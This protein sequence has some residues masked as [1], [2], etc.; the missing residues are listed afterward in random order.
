MDKIKF[1]LFVSLVIFSFLSK[2]QKRDTKIK[3]F[4]PEPILIG[5][6]DLNEIESNYFLYDVSGNNKHFYNGNKISHWKRDSLNH[7]IFHK[8]TH[9][10]SGSLILNKFPY[11]ILI[12]F[13]VTKSKGK[14]TL[15]SCRNYFRS[16]YSI[17]LINESDENWIEIDYLGETIRAKKKCEID[18][19][20]TVVAVFT[21]KEMSLYMN[22]E[23]VGSR[24]HTP[25]VA[26]NDVNL[27]FGNHKTNP[28][29][30]FEGV[31]DELALW[32]GVLTEKQLSNITYPISTQT[33]IH[34]IKIIIYLNQGRHPFKNTEIEENEIF[35]SLET[36]D[37]MSQYPYTS[38]PK[39]FNALADPFGYHCDYSKR[40]ELLKYVRDNP[41]SIKN[42]FFFLGDLC[43]EMTPYILEYYSFLVYYN[44]NVNERLFDM[45]IELYFNYPDLQLLN[46]SRSELSHF[47][48]L[49]D[50]GKTPL[51]YATEFGYLG[52][53]KKIIG[54]SNVNQQNFL[55]Q[56]ALSNA[57]KNNDLQLMSLLWDYGAN[58]NIKDQ[59]GKKPMDYCTTTEAKNLFFN[60]LIA[61]EKDQKVYHSLEEALKR[62]ERVFKLNLS[63]QYL[64]QLPENIVKFKNLK[65]LDL[66]NNLFTHFPEGISELTNL[67][68]LNLSKNQLTRL[69]ESIYKMD[70]LKS[71]LLSRNQLTRLP[72]N[73]H[74]MSTL[75]S[76]DIS[77]NLLTHL[78]DNIF[79]IKSLKVLNLSNNQLSS[80]GAG[81]HNLKNLTK[82]RL[83]G[84][85]LTSLPEKMYTMK[86]ITYL[87]LSFN[88]LI[89]ISE[90]IQQMERL[91]YLWLSNNQL[92]RLPE[93]LNKMHTIK[94]LNIKGNHFLQEEKEKIKKLPFYYEYEF[95]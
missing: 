78:S 38:N 8:E 21:E 14:N 20:Y 86:N 56:T 30:E 95:K 83:S 85:Q 61:A 50:N 45:V 92:T 28:N 25:Y 94:Y 68:S 18:K 65:E 84:N 5:L 91:T 23:Q 57:C 7:F 29:Q 63:N 64:T 37:F 75:E 49:D 55:G 66:S 16:A 81:I 36:M 48:R 17:Q 80:L 90:D 87:D 15:I 13:K 62:P 70:S 77:F 88:L 72:E 71:L 41:G 33:N 31:I 69:P 54:F 32:E 11:T 4:I 47:K 43:L 73:I 44:Q 9:F 89:H 19:W 27:S 3:R 51:M 40:E 52:S 76:L 6:W 58:E 22:G 42:P 39:E 60:L 2:G 12:K 67:V 35:S 1:V 59:Y 46:G 93:S 82:L 34:D 79:K 24:S 74:K 26:I 10:S 53:A